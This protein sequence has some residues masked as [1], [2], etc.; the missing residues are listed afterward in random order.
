MYVLYVCVCVCIC[1]LICL[2][3]CCGVLW[4]RSLRVKGNAP[5]DILKGFLRE[6]IGTRK[7]PLALHRYQRGF[8]H[9]FDLS[10][11]H[12]EA[13]CGPQGAESTESLYHGC[14]LG[15]MG[16][17]PDRMVVSFSDVSKK[18]LDVMQNWCYSSFKST[19]AR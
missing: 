19:S 16:I 15:A 3:G 8:A 12:T 4:A 17:V 11:P 7:A 1:A 6:S 9:L 2:R 13:S 18:L 10:L 5:L 14:C